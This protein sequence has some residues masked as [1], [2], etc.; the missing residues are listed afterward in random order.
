MGT[1]A[2]IRGF[3]VLACLRL[4]E[5]ARGGIGFLSQVN[6]RVGEFVLLEYEVFVSCPVQLD[7]F[8][9]RFEYG[10]FGVGTILLNNLGSLSLANCNV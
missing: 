4:W 10:I 6:N 2:L 8:V 7:G 9:T 3:N 1:I 5:T